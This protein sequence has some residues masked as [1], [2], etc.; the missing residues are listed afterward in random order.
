MIN[1]L[2]NHMS[3]QA[4]GDTSDAI[5]KLDEGTGVDWILINLLKWSMASDQLSLPPE[6]TLGGLGSTLTDQ[7][8][9]IISR[10]SPLT[11]YEKP[12]LK[13]LASLT[14]AEKRKKEME[15][16]ATVRKI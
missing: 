2:L 6:L 11:R 12:D 14:D 3:Q 8:Q 13:D 16:A 1:K 5:E 4:S 9:R 10:L 15:D 7:F